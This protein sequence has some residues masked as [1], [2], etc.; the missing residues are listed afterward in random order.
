MISFKHARIAIASAGLALG[1]AGCMNNND[2]KDSMMKAD[3]MM[4]EGQM[5]RDKGMKMND[6]DMQMKGEKMMKDGQMMKDDSM[7]KG[8]M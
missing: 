2:G 8:K 6:A 3:K 5:M 4:E 7:G 1:L